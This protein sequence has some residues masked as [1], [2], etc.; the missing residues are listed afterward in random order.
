MN[1]INCQHL[2]KPTNEFRQYVRDLNLIEKD[3]K[4]KSRVKGSTSAQNNKRNEIVAI[5]SE[6]DR[7]GFLK[8]S[9]VFVND[10]L[11]NRTEVKFDSLG[12][13]LLEIKYDSNDSILSSAQYEFDSSGNPIIQRSFSSKGLIID[14]MKYNS[15]GNITEK[16]T[17]RFQTGYQDI[18]NYY[19]HNDSL[20]TGYYSK[21]EID[22]VTHHLKGVSTSKTNIDS[23]FLTDDG[24]TELI[25]QIN[26][27]N[28]K[29]IKETIRKKY[30]KLFVKISY[31]FE[32]DLWH[33]KDSTFTIDT[34]GLKRVINYKYN[35]E[36]LLIAEIDSTVDKIGTD[37]WR[38]KE[39]Y[40][41][42]D[43]LNQIVERYEYHTSSNY[44]EWKYS[45]IFEYDKNGNKIL[46]LRK[47][48]DT[49][50]SEYDENNNLISEEYC[51][52]KFY[53]CEIRYF[54]DK[55][56]SKLYQEKYFPHDLGYNQYD[57]N[58]RYHRERYSDSSFFK[59]SN[60]F[61]R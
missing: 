60:Y 45:E 1:I 43:E 3:K 38:I 9:I 7:K 14:T 42:Y 27:D 11:I 35:D 23:T 58:L 59:K 47:N 41:K 40:F 56:G 17:F 22:P 54:Y 21:Q 61:I 53:D 13:K 39:Q 34:G 52:N 49:T 15:L 16:S 28:N 6:Y 5:Q 50:Y 31:G 29:L 24:I 48:I 46:H 8:K 12:N 26:Y 25:H 32:N 4:F 44:K 18:E 55:N 19:Y 20:L 10:S 51:A 33:I 30:Q 57:F 2:E 36:G 37:E